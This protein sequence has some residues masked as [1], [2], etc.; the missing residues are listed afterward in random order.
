MI[1]AV[2]GR[3]GSGK[4]SIGR[5]LQEKYNFE[6]YKFAYPIK[7][8]AY[9]IFQWTP[10]HIEG[11][12]KEEID[13]DWGIS[14]RQFMQYFGTE[15]MQ[16]YIG[17]LFPLFK[18]KVGR[19]LWVRRFHKW[20]TMHKFTNVVITDM[21]FIH[22]HTYLMD[23]MDKKEDS[24]FSITIKRNIENNEY[25]N[26]A[27]EKEIDLIETNYFIDNNGSWLDLFNR[28]DNAYGYFKTIEIE[29]NR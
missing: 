15:I 8:V 24:V 3:K 1:I 2:T 23:Y 11:S 17:D 21:R 14:P 13:P 20:Y 4:D 26:H 12:L 7:E 18:E 6:I 19:E 9:S 10:E 16:Y 28:I 29:R 27:S 25:S 22:E 5:F